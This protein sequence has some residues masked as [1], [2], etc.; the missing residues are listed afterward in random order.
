MNWLNLNVQTL[1]S[2]QFI[3]SEPT[4]RATWLCLLRY[5]MG[6]ENGGTI[7]DCADWK[8]RKWQ[9]LVRITKDEIARESELWMWDGESVIVW[10]YPNDK[11]SE[12]QERRER[13]K[14]NG[15]NG[16]RPKKT[17]VGLPKEPTLVISGKA[18]GEE[19]EKEKRI[20]ENRSSPSIPQPEKTKEQPASQPDLPEVVS[21]GRRF[22]DH[23]AIIATINALRPE[24]ARPSHWSAAELH[25]FHDA[26]SGLYEITPQEWELLKRYLAATVDKAAGYWQPRNRS[27]FLETF[28]D[29]F[30]SAQRWAGKTGHSE[31][32]NMKEGI[33]K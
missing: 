12:V 20:E 11:E 6:Q 2:P 9:Q 19:K 5:C 28:P 13:A 16:G 15:K 4:D 17:D 23:A 29:V 27:K 30:A 18:E 14:T 22:P 31:K 24:W 25:A 32:P 26:C 10:G 8:D 3:G 21:T 1:D 33:W 7:I